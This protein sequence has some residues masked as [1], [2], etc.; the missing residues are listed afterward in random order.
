MD[1]SVV[2]LLAMLSAHQVTVLRS[3]TPVPAV[4][5]RPK[6]GVLHALPACQAQNRTIAPSKSGDDGHTLSLRL[7][8]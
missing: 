2:Y 3:N 8:W 7:K 1:I 5:H 6:K 4:F